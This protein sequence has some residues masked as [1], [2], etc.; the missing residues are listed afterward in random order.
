[1]EALD[2]TDLLDPSAPSATFG[3]SVA[4]LQLAAAVAST[5]E[6]RV[7]VHARRESTPAAAGSEA[8]R[9]PRVRSGTLLHAFPALPTVAA[10]A[11]CTA[12]S[13]MQ[14]SGSSPALPVFPDGIRLV[15]VELV[16]AVPGRPEL[17]LEATMGRVD[18]GGRDSAPG[19]IPWPTELVSLVPEAETEQLPLPV[20]A[21][22][23]ISGTRR[24]AIV[25]GNVV[26]TGDPVGVRA[27]ARIERA[28]VVLRDPSGREVYVAIRSR[29]PP[30]LGS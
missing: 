16:E 29:K 23:M 8:L 4:S 26:A 12:W 13:F 21:G 2:S 11:F 5:G 14:V 30:A 17:Q 19:A 9:A 10:L 20:V 25:G 3:D 15:L 18:P 6:S 24:L 1:V 28:G 22:I 7:L 27:I